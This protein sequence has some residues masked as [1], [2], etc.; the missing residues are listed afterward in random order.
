MFPH[1]P[2][3]AG[4]LPMDEL[5]KNYEVMLS[6]GSRTRRNWQP[7]PAQLLHFPQVAPAADLPLAVDPA[8]R[9]RN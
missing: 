8:A 5:V 9:R 2:N 1:P 6:S 3:P 4:D 7:H